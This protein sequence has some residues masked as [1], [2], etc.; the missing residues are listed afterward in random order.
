VNVA[1]GDGRPLGGNAVLLA[2]GRPMAKAVR[3]SAF[4]ATT[5]DL[6]GVEWLVGSAQPLRDDYAPVDQLITRSN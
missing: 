5:Y 4:N 2:S 1:G 3:S 6:P